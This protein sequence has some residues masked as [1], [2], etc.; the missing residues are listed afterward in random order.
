MCYRVVPVEQHFTTVTPL[1]WKA[2]KK[3]FPI[4]FIHGLFDSGLTWNR[5]K[6]RICKDTGRKGYI[7][8]LRNHGRSTWSEELTT[9][10]FIADLENFMADQNISRAIMVAHI[11]GGKPAVHLALRK[12][13]FSL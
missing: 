2:Y 10:H 13:C 12:V 6:N 11:I 8:T 3:K 7:I 4:I 1:T 5:V 9:E